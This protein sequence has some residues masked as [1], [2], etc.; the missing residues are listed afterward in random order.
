MD[1]QD[2]GPLLGMIGRLDP[3]KG[4]D[5]LAGAA[6]RLVDRGA[7][8]V[9][10]GSGDSGLV[11][12]LRALAAARPDRISLVERFDRTLAR[13]IY[14]GIDLFVMPSRFEPCGLGQLIALRYGS[15][16]IVRRTGGL[17]DTVVDEVADPGAG[18]GFAFD[19]A[20]PDALGAA[21]EA[22][23]AMHAAGG[24]AW[25]DLVQR[26]MRADFGWA[27]GSAPRYVEAY[28]R[29]IRIRRGEG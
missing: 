9:V 2:P 29:A 12:G 4:F 17:R 26:G 18:T 28:E 1:A 8:F 15:P 27:T 24:T 22:A 23:I 25:T 6:E 5:L 13:R 16:P 20:T 10:L 19:E 7:R 21:A 3:Q 11:A 14:A